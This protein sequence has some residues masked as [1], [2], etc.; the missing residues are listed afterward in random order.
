[1]APK[2]AET[3]E[4]FSNLMRKYREQ[5]GYSSARAFYKGMGGR[6]FFGCT[7]KQY[8]NVESGRSAPQPMLVERVASGLRVA[9]DEVRAREF[10]LAYL[11]K[12]FGREALLDFIVAALSGKAA[13][14]SAA[15]PLRQAIKRGYAERA[16]PLTRA[17]SELI[18][19]S[20]EN[21]WCFTLLANDRSRWDAADVARALGCDPPAVRAALARLAQAKLVTKDRSGRWSCPLAGR[22]FMHPREAPYLP[23]LSANLRRRWKEMA[24]VHG[25]EILHQHLFTRASE[26]ALRGY[27]PYLAQSIQ[28][29][30]IYTAVEKGPDTAFFLLE[31][32]VQRVMRF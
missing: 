31:T 14:A 22:V 28:G 8:L 20:R 4:E 2:P 10:A 12:T 32:R 25:T 16:V 27:F 30:D 26:T 6:P 15:S 13:P 18:T 9:V 1:M 23:K 24:E 11:R 7:Y 29:A 5:G 21:Y 17:Q 19:A 3:M